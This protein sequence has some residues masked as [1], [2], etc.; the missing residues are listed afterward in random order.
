ME[1]AVEELTPL[2]IVEQP[3]VL[4][5]W[6]E[7]WTYSRA[8]EVHSNLAGARDIERRAI[9]ESAM[10]AVPPPAWKLGFDQ[11]CR[12]VNRACH[13]GG[14]RAKFTLERPV[15]FRR[16]TGSGLDLVQ[17]FPQ[18]HFSH[19]PR[20]DCPEL[21]IMAHC[22][23]RAWGYCP[24]CLEASPSSRVCS[25]LNSKPRRFRGFLYFSV[26]RR[27][28]DPTPTT[29]FVSWSPSRPA[30]PRGDKSRPIAPYTPVGPPGLITNTSHFQQQSQGERD[31]SLGF[32]SHI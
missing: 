11:P 26:N 9:P 7:V 22:G 32:W 16:A 3:K 12:S 18:V 15:E 28:P 21:Y 29:A 25:S 17:K 13:M 2:G 10:P 8:G 6:S 23:S 4:G 27:A 24:G 31:L 20:A 5:A 30:R 1:A 14:D 19:P